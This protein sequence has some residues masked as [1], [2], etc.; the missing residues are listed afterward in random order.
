MIGVVTY[1]HGWYK[2]Y[3]PVFV[4]AVRAAYPEY[5][6]RIFCEEVP[7]F[8]VDAELIQ[9][10]N[11]HK[12][13]KKPYYLRWLLPPESFDGFTQAFICDVDLLMLRESPCMHEIRQA[14]MTK[15][16]RPYANY[17]R[18]EAPDHPERYTGWHYI[19]VSPYYERVWP[20]AKAILDN[21]NFDISNPPSYGYYNGFGEWQW[22]QEHLLYRLIEQAFGVDKHT[23]HQDRLAFAN[24]H[25]LHL[26]PLRGGMSLRDVSVRLPLN[27]RFWLDSSRVYDLLLSPGFLALAASANDERVRAVLGRLLDMFGDQFV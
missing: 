10:K 26:G 13:A 24:H 12:K 2:D 9:F 17:L 15:T 22:G 5:R 4:H 19:D 11:P 14:I 16:G 18:R 20:H 6:I 23:E 27:D 3:I 7:N 8:K 25:G 1:V 21:P